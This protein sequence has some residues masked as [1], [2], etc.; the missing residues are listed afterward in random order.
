MPLGLYLHVLSGHPAAIMALAAAMLA[1]GFYVIYLINRDPHRLV[2]EGENHPAWH[3]M[4]WMM[5]VGHLGLAAGY[6]LNH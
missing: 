4:Y 6:L 5:M 3:H 1:W 2:T